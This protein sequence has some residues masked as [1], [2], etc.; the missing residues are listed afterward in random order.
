[1][2]RGARLA[3]LH[4]SP[5]TATTWQLIAEEIHADILANGVDAN[6][7]LTQWYGSPTLDAALLL[8]PLFRFLPPE[9]PRIRATVLAIADRL[10]VHGQPRR[11]QTATGAV[12]PA[13]GEA[14]I[15]LCSFWLVSALTEIGETARAR[16]L[17]ERL[18]AHASPLGLYA[19]ALDPVTGRHLGNYP[20]ALTHL[21]L[22]NAVT[23]LVRTEQAAHTHTFTPANQRTP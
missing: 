12:D 10:S 13:E 23:H 15:L 6:G 19:E 21:A 22:I 9:D 18:L 20:Q 16:A 2:D 11:Y 8:A 4:D 17:C 3:R 5:G 7:V 1:M 14:P